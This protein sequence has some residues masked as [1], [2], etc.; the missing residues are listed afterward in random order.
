MLLEKRLINFVFKFE[1]ITIKK[2]GFMNYPNKSTYI[3]FS[4]NYSTSSDDFSHIRSTALVKQSQNILRDEVN[5]S[6][7]FEFGH[8]LDH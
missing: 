7:A 3:R 1:K 5:V 8:L 4:Q 2:A 6:A